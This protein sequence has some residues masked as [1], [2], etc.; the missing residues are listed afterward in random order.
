MGTKEVRSTDRPTYSTFPGR[1]LYSPHNTS[2]QM[3]SED[4]P[5]VTDTRKY[6]LQITLPSAAKNPRIYTVYAADLA[7][8]RIWMLETVGITTNPCF[9][10]LI[11]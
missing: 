9:D 3:A 1:P 5:L 6:D 4:S 11:A 10:I 8:G 7:T 2:A